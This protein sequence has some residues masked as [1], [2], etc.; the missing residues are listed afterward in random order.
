MTFFD[1]FN[2]DADGICALRQLRLAEPRTS[3]LVTGAKRDIELLRRV[4]STSSDSVTVVD[5]SLDANR[6][7][8]IRI[9]ESGARVEY[10]DH[11]HTGEIPQHPNFRGHF[12][13]SLETCTSLIVD[14]YLHQQFASW[15]IAG[16]FGD[17]L[18][19]IAYRKGK[20]LGL[21]SEQVDFL[22]RCGQLLNYNSYGDTLED[23]HFAPESLYRKM[24]TYTDPFAFAQEAD[25][26]HKLEEGYD[27]DLSQAEKITP[28]SQSEKGMLFLLPNLPWARRVRGIFAN[29]AAQRFPEH[30]IA[31]LHQKDDTS[32]VVSIRIPLHGF[33]AADEFCR[34]FPTGGGRAA[35]AGINRLP[36]DQLQAFVREFHAAFSH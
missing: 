21:T 11:H 34:R 19:D 35:A 23:L 20:Q 25:V 1:V 9:L 12:D 31:M 17:G 32:F 14:G 30:A 16:A 22:R 4:S 26:F 15:A 29:L 28:Y 6:S 18:S 27:S 5:I 33:L 3:V 2:G 36:Q 13:V 24:E 10:F 8:L 7:D